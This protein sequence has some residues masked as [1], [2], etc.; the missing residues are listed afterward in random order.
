MKKLIL[1]MLFFSVQATAQNCENKDVWEEYINE[2]YF[3]LGSLSQEE[4]FKN[5]VKKVT[6]EDL[7]N[8]A[9]LLCKKPK[10]EKH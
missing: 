3:Y 6:D 8:M 10:K 7:E 1:L 2:V 9:I 4:G 5:R